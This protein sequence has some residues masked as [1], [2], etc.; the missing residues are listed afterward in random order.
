MESGGLLE[1]TA[2]RLSSSQPD[3]GAACGSNWRRNSAC[4]CSSEREHAGPAGPT[5]RRARH[6]QARAPPSHLGG[7]DAVARTAG[8]AAEA[9]RREH[10]ARRVGQP[11]GGEFPAAAAAGGPCACASRSSPSRWCLPT[12]SATCLRRGA[13]IAI[14]MVRPSQASLIAR[15]VASV[16]RMRLRPRRLPAPHRA[17]CRAR[18][19]GPTAPRAGGLRPP[20]TPSCAVSPRHGRR[21]LAR[22][23][24][25]AQRRRYRA[26][27]ID[28][29]RA[30]RGVLPRAI[31][32]PG[33]RACGS[34]CRS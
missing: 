28:P 19:A 12:K 27:A 20:G 24:R 10:R 29:R 18:H 16:P 9:R 15:K 21:G 34:C 11:R 23:V 22:G 32:P 17:H 5:R 25:R 31:S 14:R 13:D 7:A 30:G 3:A 4:R 8:R 6:R 2:R 1:H 26:V 33:I